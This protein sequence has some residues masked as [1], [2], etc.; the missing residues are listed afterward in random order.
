[1]QPFRLVLLGIIARLVR[2][3]AL[4]FLVLAVIIV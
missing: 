2:R 3:Q 4:N 1:M